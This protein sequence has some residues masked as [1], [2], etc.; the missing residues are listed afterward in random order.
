[1]NYF[2]MFRELHKRNLRCLSLEELDAYATGKLSGR[3]LAQAEEHLRACTICGAE[4]KQLNAFLNL[5]DEEIPVDAEQWKR[6]KNTLDLQLDELFRSRRAR[7]ESPS[8]G[9]KLSAW[10]S[11]L[12]LLLAQPAYVRVAAM[13]ALVL[14]IGLVVYHHGPY[15]RPGG[16]PETT[17]RRSEQAGKIKVVQPLGK[18][19]RASLTFEWQAVPEAKN[20]IVELYTPD[21]ETLWTSGEIPT[22]RLSLPQEIVGKLQT[23]KSYLWKVRAFDENNKMIQDSSVESFEL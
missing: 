5:K 9:Q 16:L 7:A 6:A 20:Y 19:S 13:L 8:L 10:W 18:V 4:L 15:W 12:W 23:G 1:M 22:N 14:G 11:N 2:Q 21:L 17:E 3:E